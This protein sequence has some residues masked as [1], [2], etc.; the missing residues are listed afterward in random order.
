[1]FFSREYL[2]IHES[3]KESSIYFIILLLNATYE[4]ANLFQ[5]I[6]RQKNSPDFS[7]CYHN[8]MQWAIKRILIED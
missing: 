3:S 2:L 4:K 7:L 8:S 1:M 6:S 5:Y